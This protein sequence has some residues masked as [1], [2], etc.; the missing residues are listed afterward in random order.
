MKEVL[1]HNSV[2]EKK[3]PGWSWITKWIR[4]IDRRIQIVISK[5]LDCDI[6]TF[7]IW[8]MIFTKQ[9]SD[10]FKLRMCPFRQR[11]RIRSKLRV[12][13][14]GFKELWSSWTL[15]KLTPYERCNIMSASM[16]VS[17]GVCLCARPTVPNRK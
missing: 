16:Y 11:W 3:T 10:W 2:E 7:I 4:L 5:E 13:K 12:A 6:V 17:V 8:T 15:E 9:E 14:T 1:D